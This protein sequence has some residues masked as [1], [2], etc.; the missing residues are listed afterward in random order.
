MNPLLILILTSVSLLA[1]DIT[2]SDGTVYK[3][4]TII[5]SDPSTAKITH[6]S[7]VARIPLERLPAPLQQRLGYD[8][9]KAEVFK[10]EQGKLALDK[11]I[12]DS[13]AQVEKLIDDSALEVSVS[14]SQVLTGGILISDGK[15][16]CGPV[17]TRK[18]ETTLKVNPGDGD[19]LS[20]GVWRQT[21]RTVTD[22]RY[23]NYRETGGLGTLFIEGDFD[24]VFDGG[25]W[26]GKI[27]KSGTY[28]FTTVLGA[29][30]TVPKYTSIR[31]P[32]LPKPIAQ[33]E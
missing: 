31:P 28:S 17:K 21:D 14:I 10:Q 30:R 20:Q 24:G 3:E 2:L 26:S 25:G 32:I 5:S 12:S 15:Y 6:E 7:G 23:E 19:P 33:N 27:W 29:R 4:A 16:T 22:F 1:E 9:A 13:K 11:K 18:V 8:P